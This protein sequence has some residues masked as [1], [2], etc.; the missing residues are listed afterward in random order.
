[1]DSVVGSDNGKTVTV[2]YQA[3]KAYPDWKSLFDALYP[4]HLAK[5]NGDDGTAAGLAKSWEWFKA[6][7]PTWSG[8]PFMIESYTEGQQLI[9]V[10]NP[11]WYG[12]EAGPGEV[13]LQD[14]DRPIVVRPGA[15]ER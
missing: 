6:T 9:Q 4:A 2:T 11:K 12:A 10:P 13:D 14:R 5:K 3:G 7:Q 15:A 1:M 8:G